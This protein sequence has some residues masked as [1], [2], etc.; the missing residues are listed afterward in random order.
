MFL[1]RTLLASATTSVT[2]CYPQ[3]SCF[4][5]RLRKTKNYS[6]SGI[7]KY[8]SNEDLAISR[9]S[10]KRKEKYQTI[11]VH[12]DL[13]FLKVRKDFFWNKRTKEKQVLD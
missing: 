8:E 11:Q 2:F 7:N 10:K 3:N 9:R 12:S 1:C 13:G 6:Q 4:L 5:F